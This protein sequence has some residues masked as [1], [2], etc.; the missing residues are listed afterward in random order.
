VTSE[1]QATTTARPTDLADARAA[2]L[3]T[4]GPMVFRGGG[5][6][7][8]WGAAPE[9]VDVVVDTAAM[10][11]LLTHDPA[12]ATASV[13]AGMPLRALQRQLAEHGQ[14]LAVDPPGLDDGVTVGG[15]FAANDAGPNRLR[16]GTMRDLVIGATFVLS[17]G[18][19]GRTGGFVIKNVAGYDMARLLCGSLGT[20]ALVAELVIRV[21]PLPEVASTLRVPADVPTAT[22]HAAA[23]AGSPVEPTAV[24]WS[25]GALWVRFAGRPAV[26]EAQI[27]RARE[28]LTAD[29]EVLDGDDDAAAW[30]SLTDGLGGVG[31]ETV[32]RAG[33]L[34][35]QVPD[36][37]DAVM[38]AAAA[39]GVDV[40][41]SAHCLVGAVTA[42]L[43]GGDTAG[44]AACVSSWRERLRGMGGHAIMRRRRD[45]VDDLVDPW[46]PAP[47]GIDLM[48][49]VKRALD[50]GNRCAPGRFVGGI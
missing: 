27:A 11:A 5:T 1:L 38:V 17:D 30:R 18:T 46:G 13:Q 43:S 31:G 8:A 48:R 12:D 24:D 50:P 23:I 4:A 9:A 19:I 44:H 37:V 47:P 3:D 14:W 40:T 35:T 29:G 25:D 10:D 39:A 26:V 42:R 16:H 22:R 41:V 28:V 20:L 34:P 6:K 2:V 15:V 33:C 32:V 21:H 36:A 45:G 7:L 49:R